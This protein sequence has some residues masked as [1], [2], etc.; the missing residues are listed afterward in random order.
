MTVPDLFATGGVTVD[1]VRTAGGAEMRGLLGGGAAYAAAGARAWCGRAGVV[2]VAPSNLPG[3]FLPR[4]AAAGIDPGGVAAA[5]EAVTCEEWMEYGADGDRRDH[6]CA[7]PGRGFAEFRAANPVLPVHVPTAWASAH[8]MHLAPNR[9]DAQLA[10]A[11]WARAAGLVVTL[12]PGFHAA[13]LDLP[14]LLPLLD[15]FL[16]SERELRALFPSL[17]PEAGLRRLVALGAPVA[18]VKLGAVGALV[19]DGRTGTLTGVPALRVAA[20]DPTGAGDAWC[21]GFLSGL[22]EAADPVAAARRGAVSA[23]F[24]VEAFGP[25]RLLDAAPDEALARLRALPLLE[26]TA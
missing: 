11:R 3:S 1:N 18:A 19:L 21:G 22:C 20:C 4:L 6:L 13:A 17:S 8:A 9:P 24:A 25:D 23:S 15:A 5:P 14:A 7:G 16:P 10:L 26:T 2:S 12:D